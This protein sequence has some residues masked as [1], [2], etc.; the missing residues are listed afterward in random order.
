MDGKLQDKIAVADAE[1]R[2]AKAKLD[3]D[4]GIANDY[5]DREPTPTDAIQKEIDQ[6]ETMKKHI[7]EFRRM[8]QM[9]KEVDQL[10]ADADELTRKIELARALPGE[11]LSKAKIPVEGLTVEKGIPLVNGLPISN[12]SDGEKLDLC[13]DVTLAKKRDGVLQIILIDG[14][15][16]LDKNSRAALYEKCKAKGLQFI[17]TRVTDGDGL[18]VTEL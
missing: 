18:E 7:N 10:Q 6:A 5:A 15:E 11:I 12:L 9:Q 4:I 1:F 8:Q 14:A 17:A 2:E 16:R 13:V 3:A